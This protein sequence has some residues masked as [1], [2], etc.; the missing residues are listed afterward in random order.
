MAHHP[1]DN[2]NTSNNENMQDVLDRAIQSPARRQIFRGG[3]GLAAAASLPMLPAC[4]GDSSDENLPAPPG[5]AAS[6][7]P[8]ISPAVGRA[9]ADRLTVPMATS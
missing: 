4:G 9:L 8:L 6:P 7:N 3:L 2:F 5:A 1:D